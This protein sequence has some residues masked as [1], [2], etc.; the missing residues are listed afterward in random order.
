[1]KINLIK[2][3]IS[4]FAIMIIFSPFAHAG[5]LQMANEGGL[6]DIGKVYTN[7]AAPEDIRITAMK[8]IKV[9]L[10][11]TAIIL[12][13]YIVY[14]GFQWMTAGGNAG[15]VTTAKAHIINAVIGLII[16]FSAYGLANF[17]ISFALNQAQGGTFT[18]N[19][20]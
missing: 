19:I 1:M 12:I 8:Y 3:L 18:W 13:A 9:L 7:N 20:I 2:Y 15:Q 10:G 17:I 5:I 16:I 11:F 4:F 14:A 6:K